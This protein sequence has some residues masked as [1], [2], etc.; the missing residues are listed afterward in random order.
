MV[1]LF[2]ITNYDIAEPMPDKTTISKHPYY[3]KI[4][5]AVIFFMIFSSL[6]YL[7]SNAL[8]VMKKSRNN[9]QITIQAVSPEVASPTEDRKTIFL[10]K[11]LSENFLL[12][13]SSD[14]ILIIVAATSIIL[15]LQR[16]NNLPK[17]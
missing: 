10:K 3:K 6:F 14:I 7:S 5:G 15:L 12:K 1:V 16:R 17:A 2:L 13:R 4:I 8:Y 11:K 9:H